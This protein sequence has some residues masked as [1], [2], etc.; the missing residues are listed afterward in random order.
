MLGTPVTE[1]NGGAILDGIRFHETE[2]LVLAHKGLQGVLKPAIDE[3]GARAHRFERLA[4]LVE[5]MLIGLPNPREGLRIALAAHVLGAVEAVTVLHAGR[6]GPVVLADAKLGAV[7]W[8]SLP[9]VVLGRGGWQERAGGRIGWDG[10]CFPLYLV[11][12]PH[13]LTGLFRR[14]ISWD[15]GAIRDTSDRG[16]AAFLMTDGCRSDA[17]A[18]ARAALGPRSQAPA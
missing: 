4:A 11:R 9:G 13:E 10:C 5:V 17:D 6:H 7:R 14:R 3:G 18:V 1:S 15:D 16:E 8:P 12:A 2:K